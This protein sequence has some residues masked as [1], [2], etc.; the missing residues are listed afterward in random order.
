MVRMVHG[1]GLA[2]LFS[3][4]RSGEEEFAGLHAFGLLDRMCNPDLLLA[5]DREVIARAMHEEYVRNQ[6]AKDDG[7]EAQTAL[8][9]PAL[10]PWDQLSDDLK[11]SNRAQAA[12]VGI[13]LA[14]VGCELSPL[15]AW[16]AEHFTFVPSELEKLAQMEHQRFVEER[17]GA[18]WRLGTRAPD[19]KRS[20]Y[21]VPWSD[22]E[23]EV[24][25]LDRLFIRGLPKFLARAGFQI[26]RVEGGD[27]EDPGE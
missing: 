26:V 22:L 15:T 4:D 5:G 1:A 17:I 13:K 18:G 21:L 14:A 25:D 19:R 16:D 20:P 12:H 8:P 9:Q 7:D 23:E 10:E 6:Q 11:E 27:G 2:S 24:R 3:E